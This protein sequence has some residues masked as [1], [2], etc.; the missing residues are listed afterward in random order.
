MTLFYN[1]NILGGQES[2]SMLKDNYMRTYPIPVTSKHSAFNSGKCHTAVKDVIISK[3]IEKKKRELDNIPA[4]SDSSISVP[5]TQESEIS[6]RRIS[7]VRYY[8]LY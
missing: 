1:I 4:A 6:K 7:T 8:G 2:D 5:E 3:M